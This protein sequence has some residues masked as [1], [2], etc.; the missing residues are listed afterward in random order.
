MNAMNFADKVL[1]N[2]N[3]RLHNLYDKFKMYKLSGLNHKFDL[4]LTSLRRQFKRKTIPKIII[5]KKS[6]LLNFLLFGAK[7]NKK[8]KMIRCIWVKLSLRCL[9]IGKV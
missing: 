5:E 9:S 3:G 2:E 1:A 4:N 7:Q 8:K 6:H